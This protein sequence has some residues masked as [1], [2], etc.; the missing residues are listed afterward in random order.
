MLSFL[1][2]YSHS[3]SDTLIPILSFPYSHSH[4]L[5]PRL[6]F[7]DSHSHT[8]I[9]IHMLSYSHS[10]TLIPIPM[11]SYSHSNTLI[12][13]PMLSYSHSNTLI[14]IPMLSY[15]HLQVLSSHCAIPEGASASK[16]P[17]IGQFSSV[18][19]L[20]PSPSQWLTSEWL[21]S[22]SSSRRASRAP[23]ALLKTPPLRLVHCTK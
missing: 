3:D 23:S 13:I 21:V 18:G 4:T 6:S 1:L 7:P 19:S 17:V 11:L 15:S 16:W 2:S 5:I 14:P 9:P 10:H 8:L 12:P 22:L 20:G